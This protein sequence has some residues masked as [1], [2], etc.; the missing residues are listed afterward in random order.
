MDTYGSEAWKLTYEIQ[1]RTIDF[2]C[3]IHHRVLKIVEKIR[4]IVRRWE[5]EGDKHAFN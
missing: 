5:K 3:W 4:P 1:N 2:E